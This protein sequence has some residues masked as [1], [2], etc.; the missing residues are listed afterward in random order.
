[1]A[2]RKK[3]TRQSREVR[4]KA[5]VEAA[6]QVFEQQGYEKAKVSDIADM[7]GVVEG[8]VFSYFGSKRAL[9]LR[10]M[11]EFY[12]EITSVIEGGINAVEGTRNRLHFV[13]WNHLSIVSKNRALCAVI[14]RESRGLDRELAQGV[15]DLNKRYTNIIAQI[16]NEGITLGDIR[17]DVS[18]ALVRNTIFGTIEHYLWDLVSGVPEVNL[19]SVAADL[20]QLVFSGI[21]CTTNDASKSDVKHLI[22]KLNQLL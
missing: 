10:V 20:T 18:S 8:T 7:I 1:M 11:E 6:R 9:V 21:S 5:I 13:I 22:K 14:L 2:A 19:D 16:V 3:S 17:S 4:I 12:D 15:H